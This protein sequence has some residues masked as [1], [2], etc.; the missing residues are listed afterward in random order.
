[1]TSPFPYRVKSAR[2]QKG[3]TQTQLAQALGISKQAISQYEHGRKKPE[4]STLIALA[5]Y[6]NKPVDY[7]LRP[8]L[9]PLEQ[10]EFR[11]E[12]SLGGRRLEATKAAIQ[13]K[14]EP[15][16]EL[17]QILGIASRFENPLDKFPIQTPQ[18]A[19]YAA[20]Q[21][22]STWKLGLNPIPNILEMLENQGI[23]LVHMELDGDFDGLSTWLN[24]EIPVIVL[25]EKQDTVRIRFTAMHELGHLLLQ[26]PP[27][28]LHKEKLCNRF[29]G[30]MLLP[31]QILQRE[32]GLHRRRISLAELIPLKEYYGISLAALMYRLQDLE[33]LPKALTQRFWKARR[34]DKALKQELPE[35]GYG[36]YKGEER[37]FRFEQLLSKALAEEFISYS[38]A[39]ALTGTDLQ[40]L[41]AQHPFI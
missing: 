25:N 29:A 4:S 39:A 18:D 16:L 31:A 33:I 21:L 1:M 8:V 41:K 24:Q 27:D 20:I 3:I 37:A 32:L 9:A 28:H 26:V 30:A 19:E 14:L 36:K 35:H 15:Y 34:Q 40:K 22:Q 5:Q 23:K 38:K 12:L 7:F 17:E 13:D 6:F 2:I 11:K 10:V